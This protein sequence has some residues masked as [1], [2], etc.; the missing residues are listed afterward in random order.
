MFGHPVDTPNQFGRTFKGYK[1]IFICTPK[2]SLWP[3]HKL[4]CFFWKKKLKSIK[5]HESAICINTFIRFS[6]CYMFVLFFLWSKLFSKNYYSN[7]F[8][9]VKYF[10]NYRSF[11]YYKSQDFAY[12][13]HTVEFF[14]NVNWK[15]RVKGIKNWYELTMIYWSAYQST[16]HTFNGWLELGLYHQLLPYLTM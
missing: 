13:L 12:G 11:I 6:F 4:L 2:K 10:L 8:L 7:I 9:F 15:W 5:Y 1:S 3:L 14:S 16:V